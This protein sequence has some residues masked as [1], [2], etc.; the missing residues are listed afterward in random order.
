VD[1]R[2]TG[3]QAE[4]SK[5][6]PFGSVEKAVRSHVLGL[7][8]GW[9]LSSVLHGGIVA[10]VHIRTTQEQHRRLLWRLKMLGYASD[11]DVWILLKPRQIGN[12]IPPEPPLPPKSGVHSRQSWYN[13]A[14]TV[15]LG[16]N[17]PRVCKLVSFT[18]FVVSFLYVQHLLLRY[19]NEEIVC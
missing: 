2:A 19:P 7:G 8:G 9:A 11:R 10:N 15:Y 12:G 1:H 13:I 3:E 5:K 6:T 17:K 14:R 18:A 4:I 16:R